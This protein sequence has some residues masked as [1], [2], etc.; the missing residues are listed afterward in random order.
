LSVAHEMDWRIPCALVAPQA[1]KAHRIR[2]WRIVCAP[3]AQVAHHTRI[4][5][6]GQMGQ[7]W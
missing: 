2:H 5:G 4:Q 3:E 1:Q 6:A 7:P